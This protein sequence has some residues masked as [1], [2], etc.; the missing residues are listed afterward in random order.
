MVAFS[1]ALQALCR[2]PGLPAFAVMAVAGAICAPSGVRLAGCMNNRLLKNVLVIVILVA[3]T[4]I[5]GHSAE[6][7]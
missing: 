3:A 1:A 7:E 6:G 2:F 4:V 5:A